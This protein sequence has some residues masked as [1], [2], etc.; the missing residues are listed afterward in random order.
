MPIPGK[1]GG[2]IDPSRSH[3]AW[4]ATLR[5][6]KGRRGV[7]EVGYPPHGNMQTHFDGAAGAFAYLLLVVLL[8]TCPALPPWGPGYERPVASGPC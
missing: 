3:G 6:R 8:S 4:L 5:T 1:S 2:D 7:Q